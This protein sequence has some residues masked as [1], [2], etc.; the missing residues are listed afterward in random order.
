VSSVPDVVA[1]GA[2][3]A[4]DERSA[5]VGI[6][7]LRDHALAALAFAV[8]SGS[9]RLPVEIGWLDRFACRVGR[10]AGAWRESLTRTFMQPAERDVPLLDLAHTLGLT[11]FE[12]LAVTLAAAVEDDMMAGRAVAHLQAPIAGSRPMVGLL[13]TAFADV[14]GHGPTAADLLACGEAVQ[15]GLLELPADASPLPERPVSVPLHVCLA[16]HGRDGTIDGVRIGDPSDSIVP[17]PPSMRVEAT[18]HAHAL[19]S[20]PGRALVVRSASAAEARS[21]ICMIAEALNRRPLFIEG[22]MPAGLTPWILLRGLV[23]VFSVDPGPGERCVLPRPPGYAGPVLAMAGPDGAVDARNAVA[24]EWRVGIPAAPERRR[25]WE[26]ATG[27]PEL[28]ADLAGGHRYGPGRIAWLGRL[29]AHC[30]DIADN[31]SGSRVTHTHVAAAAWN[32]E[33]GGLDALAR[34]VT[35]RVPDDAFVAAP[36]LAREMRQ[37]VLRCTLRDG[38][39]DGLGAATVTRYRPGVR[40]LF[41]GPSGTGKTLG[42]AWIATKLGVPLF[43]VDLASITSKYIGETEKNLAQ[44]LARAEHAGVI[45]LFDEADSLFGK[46]TDVKDSNDR[47]ANA[48]TN[49]L[50]QRI[51]T[52]EG[53]VLLTSNSRGRFD[54][55]FAR[56]LDAIIDF[57]LPGPDERRALWEAHL[58]TRHDLRQQDINQF[59]ARVELAGGHIRTAVLTAAALAGENSNRINRDHL[60]H[61]IATECRK[62]G[63]PMPAELAALLHGQPGNA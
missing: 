1:G 14:A 48:Q 13:A 11:T 37:L 35:D 31:G 3:G 6:L 44:L 2:T 32:I 10:D 50:L 26:L 17:L 29:A 59:A 46:R 49:Y 51:E 39:V 27:D 41:V 61:G 15:S 56:R 53:I 38:L 36:V 62:L 12:I 54:S 8:P 9:G 18:H 40:A 22:E 63:R 55:A 23:P 42:A 24:T 45:L 20:A 47:F 58:G 19:A 34:A 33:G 52:Y 28:A 4:A 7:T 16:L 21:T 25:L 57:P 30:A 43:R 5:S 60:L